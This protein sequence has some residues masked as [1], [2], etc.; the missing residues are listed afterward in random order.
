MKRSVAILALAALYACSDQHTPT[1]QPLFAMRSDSSGA[2]GALI[3]T[4]VGPLPRSCVYEIEAGSHLTGPRSVVRADGTGYT[5]PQCTS[6]TRSTAPTPFGPL[7]LD[8]NYREAA[9]DSASGAFATWHK[10]TA[11]W[12]VPDAPLGSYPSGTVRAYFAFPALAN[13]TWILQPVLQYG[14]DSYFGGAYWT[15]ASYQCDTLCYHSSPLTV[16]TG[17][18]IQGSVIGACSSGKCV[19]T[20]VAKVLGTTDSTVLQ[21]TDSSDTYVYA[22]GGAVEKNGV[23][24]TCSQYP[25]DGVHFNSIALFDETDTEVWPTSWTTWINTAARPQCG[26]SIAQS[27]GLGYAYL[28]H[29]AEPAP[30]LSTLSTNPSPP[31]QYLSATYTLGGSAF[32]A[33]FAQV[34]ITGDSSITS[35]PTACTMSVTSRSATQVVANIA[36]TVPGPYTVTVKNG[37]GGGTSAG[38]NVRIVHL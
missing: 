29:N 14:N 35:C 34:F 30:T 27:G 25:Y 26:F 1:S 21:A 9:F 10:I 6:D 37:D 15:L 16:S 11:T 23:I 17:Q 19:W 20:I 24:S 12:V 38:L 32:D 13:S 5:L 33:A 22:I 3:P 7:T 8:T 4:P 18:T 28:Y 36:L 2:L 31:K